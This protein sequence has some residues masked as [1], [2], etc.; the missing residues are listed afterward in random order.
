MIYLR[1]YWIR[2]VLSVLLGRWILRLLPAKLQTKIWYKIHGP[3]RNREA[4]PLGKREYTLAA[5][6]MKRV[7][8]LDRPS[9]ILEFGTSA[10][11]LSQRLLHFVEVANGS[12]KVWHYGFDT[13]EGMPAS[14]DKADFV[15][16]GIGVKQQDWTTGS[17][18]ANEEDVRK[19]LQE[20]GFQNFT[21]FKGLFSESLTDTVI[22]EIA[23]R[24]PFLVIVDCDYYSSTVDIFRR[25]LPIVPNGCVFYFDDTYLNYFSS[26]SGELRAIKELN[27]GKFGAGYELVEAYDLGFHGR[28]FYYFVSS[29]AG[30]AAAGTSAA[31]RLAVSDWVSPGAA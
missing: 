7:P 14:N 19:R 20:H 5:V 1:F 3:V 27:E 17:F 29:R 23:K 15:F 11:A 10:G 2:V 18:A 26:L 21:L 25:I 6:I 30:L 28:R 24:P 9:S 4:A 31:G 22:A 16:E 13:F 12:D 8:K